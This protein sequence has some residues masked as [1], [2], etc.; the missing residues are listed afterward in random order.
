[1]LDLL[2]DTVWLVCHCVATGWVGETL[3]HRRQ[4]N[5]A[6]AASGWGLRRAPRQEW[7]AQ[8]DPLC[9]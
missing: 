7:E 6:V 3:G 4:E 2:G 1:M 9:L 8:D 5:W